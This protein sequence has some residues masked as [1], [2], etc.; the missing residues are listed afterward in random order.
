M[1]KKKPPR[2]AVVRFSWCFSRSGKKPTHRVVANNHDDSRNGSHFHVVEVSPGGT[3]S[4]PVLHVFNIS[5]RECPVNDFFR[6]TYTR[7]FCPFI[8]SIGSAV[9]F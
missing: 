8:T 3:D 4:F 5:D 9:R 7:V 2:G 6:D 1:T